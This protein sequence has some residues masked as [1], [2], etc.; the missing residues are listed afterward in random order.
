[1]LELAPE[2]SRPY[3]RCS[4]SAVRDSMFTFWISEGRA[5]GGWGH[6]GMG[7]Q[8]SGG[9]VYFHSISCR[10]ISCIVP[11]PTRQGSTI[12]YSW[13]RGTHRSASAVVT[14]ARHQTSKRQQT[15]SLA[16]EHQGIQSS[17][18]FLHP[19]V[20]HSS[21]RVGGKWQALSTPLAPSHAG[22]SLAG[23]LRGDTTEAMR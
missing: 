5:G 3:N 19:P 23:I 16:P 22:V 2:C 21:I 12:A 17:S 7:G 4:S 11:A 18:H 1:M 8:A 14:D 6:G 9:M 15:T 13:D 10:F 20:R